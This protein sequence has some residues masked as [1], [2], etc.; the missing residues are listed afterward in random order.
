V[1]PTRKRAEGERRSPPA[2]APGAPSAGLRRAAAYAKPWWPKPPRCQRCQRQ[3]LV[4][5][6]HHSAD[7]TCFRCYLDTP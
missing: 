5:W 3:T 2:L 1:R 6:T 4:N 7:W